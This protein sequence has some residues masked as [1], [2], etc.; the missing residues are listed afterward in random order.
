LKSLLLVLQF[1]SGY[2]HNSAQNSYCAHHLNNGETL[3][4]K[5]QIGDKAPNNPSVAYQTYKAGCVTLERND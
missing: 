5:Y 3:L 4:E 2:A 1:V